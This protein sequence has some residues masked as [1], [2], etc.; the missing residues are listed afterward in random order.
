MQLREGSF[1]TMRMDLAYGQEMYRIVKPE[2][3]MS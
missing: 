1:K 2:V 3:N